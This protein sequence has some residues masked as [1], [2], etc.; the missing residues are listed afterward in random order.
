MSE[1]RAR[2][3][4]MIALALLV[5]AGCAPAVSPPVSSDPAARPPA[6]EWPTNFASPQDIMQRYP[7]MRRQQL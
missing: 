1:P 6:A 2:V 4:A 7:T 3:S 5:A